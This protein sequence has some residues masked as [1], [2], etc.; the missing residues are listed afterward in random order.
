LGTSRR[1]PPPLVGCDGLLP[2]GPR[3]APPELAPRSA[4]CCLAGRAVERD[5]GEEAG[6]WHVARAQFR[7]FRPVI[8]LRTL[9]NTGQ[10]PTME[11]MAGNLV[12]QGHYPLPDFPS[13]PTKPSTF[14][15]HG[16]T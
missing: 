13:L 7:Q 12:H 14:S 9:K 11:R 16:P 8:K 1:G 5:R 15:V 4:G 10:L 6:P 3:P 2:F